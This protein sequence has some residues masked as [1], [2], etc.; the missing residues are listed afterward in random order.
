[1]SEGRFRR[2][3]LEARKKPPTVPQTEDVGPEG[4]FRRAE[5]EYR[6][7]NFENALRLYSRTLEMDRL[8]VEAWRRQVLM[9]VEVG[10]YDEAALWADKALEV[11]PD[12]PELV[13]VKAMAQCRAGDSTGALLLADRALRMPG[14][15]PLRWLAR[16]EVFLARRDGNHDHC[17]RMAA[18]EC[19]GDWLVE[20][21]I[22]RAYSRH[23]LL[24]PALEHFRRAL[25]LEPT[26]VYVLLEAARCEQQL[27]LGWRAKRSLEE[28]VRLRPGHLEAQREL[29]ALRAGGFG[30]QV[31]GFFRRLLGR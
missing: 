14:T 24:S 12:D 3:E 6:E 19:P 29:T 1:M 28:V 2:L 22:G 8:M 7:G 13:A 4:C 11:F 9:L 10:E 23:G 16:G 26:A 20:M 17:F 21:Q 30:R 5:G 27:G 18:G 15:S 25:D 31:K